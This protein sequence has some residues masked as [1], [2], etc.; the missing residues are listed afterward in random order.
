M[1]SSHALILSSLYSLSISLNLNKI[2]KAIRKPENSKDS[3]E[4]LKLCQK[5]E[6]AKG[7]KSGL[8]DQAA[9]LL[10]KKDKFCFVKLFPEL[11]YSYVDIPEHLAFMILPSFIKAEKTSKEYRETSKYFENY[12]KL[13][14]F[15]FDLLK[16]EPEFK[17][18]YKEQTDFY[19]G[20]LLNIYNDSEILHKISEIKYEDYKYLSLYALAEGARIKDLKNNFSENKLYSHINYSHL[21]EYINQDRKTYQETINKSKPLR[22][23]IGAYRAS[24][25]INDEIADFALKINGVYACSIIGAGLGGN[26]LAIIEKDQA[27]KIK[28]IFIEEFYSKIKEATRAEKSILVNTSSSALVQII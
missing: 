26:N 3:F 21:A 20:D 6:H 27:Q 8:G 16:N 11:K 14:E 12:G 2:L 5:I 7:F 10:S 13:N 4:I 1:S 19:L 23:H 15:W 17:K 24:T 22:E 28:K 18:I 9:Q 25:K